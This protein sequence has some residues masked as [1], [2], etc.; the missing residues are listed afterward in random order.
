MKRIRAKFEK[1]IDLLE[2]EN[3]SLIH[4]LA[5]FLFFFSLRYFLDMLVRDWSFR[6][7]VALGHVSAGFSLLFLIMVISY[8]A[9]KEKIENIAKVVVPLLCS[10]VILMSTIDF[11]AYGR[12]GFAHGYLRPEDDHILRFF[13]FFGSLDQEMGISIGNRISIM[14]GLLFFFAYFLYKNK[15][16]IKSLSFTFLAYVV[17]F[18]G[19]STPIFLERFVGILGI[20]YEISYTLLIRYFLMMIFLLL[21]VTIYLMRRKYFVDVIKNIR[22]YVLGHLIM[23]LFLGL[24][25]G[26]SQASFE[27]TMYSLSSLILTVM[28]IFLAWSFAVSLDHIAD[29]DEFQGKAAVDKEVIPSKSY[30]VIT[31]AFFFLSLI[32]SF[33]GGEKVCLFIILFMGSFMIYS[34]P[35]FRLKRVPILS[36]VPMAFNSLL[37]VILGH[38]FAGELFDMPMVFPLFFFTI[39]LLAANFVDI[40]NYE[41]DEEEGVKTIPVLLGLKKAKL[42]IGSSF[43]VAVFSSYFLID[44]VVSLN[45][46]LNTLIVIILGGVGLVELYLINREDYK[47]GPVFITYLILAFLL[48]YIIFVL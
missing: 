43:A 24:G 47:E 1:L 31:A 20:Q 25:I 23:M 44:G 6:F 42:L 29:I 37:L 33:A 5:I 3:V 27:L 45:S 32:Y 48:T 21:G 36:K 15:S 30:K 8:F 7:E 19:L 14:I 28:S 17:V 9:T 41:S 18:M 40:K 22:F 10:L 2:E 38:S 13:T 46:T 16:F 4:L 35:P 11:F 39:F 34:L 12:G 26:V